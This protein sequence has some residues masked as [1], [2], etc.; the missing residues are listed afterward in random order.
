MLGNW[1]PSKGLELE[2]NQG[3]I[4]SSTIHVGEGQLF[5]IEYKYVC[6]QGA[7]TIRWEGGFNRKLK[8][9]EGKPKGDKL[10]FELNDVWQR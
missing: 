10:V 1:D 2:W 9:S 4:W 5:D 8:V 6:L 7:G 3:N